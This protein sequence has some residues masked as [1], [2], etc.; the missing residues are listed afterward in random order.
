[1]CS[2]LQKEMKHTKKSGYLDCPVGSVST[3]YLSSQGGQRCVGERS[4]L[5][6]SETAA[7]HIS[8]TVLKCCNFKEG[9]KVI[10]IQIHLGS[11]IGTD[12]SN[13][14]QWNQKPEKPI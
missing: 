11:L 10:K 4:P 8:E 7:M 1:M 2:V 9:K 14:I 13:K 5:Q 12:F 6:C 3:S